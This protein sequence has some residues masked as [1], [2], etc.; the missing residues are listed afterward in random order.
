MADEQKI[1]PFTND[2]IFKVVMQDES[3]A[4]E[5]ISIILGKKVAKIKNYVPQKDKKVL[6]DAHGVRFDL[7]FEGDDA[8]YDVEMQNLSCVDIG[9][10]CRYYQSMIDVDILQTNETYFDLKDSYIIFLCTYDPFNE[11]LPIYTFESVCTSLPDETLIKDALKLNTGA[12]VVICN[13]LAYN[14]TKEELHDFLQYL[15]TQQV[16]GDNTFIEKIDEA[17]KFANGDEETRSKAMISDF[18]L[19]DARYEGKM[20]GLEAG[21]AQGTDQEQKRL[22]QILEYSQ[23]GLTEEQKQKL[24]QEFTKDREKP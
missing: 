17:V 5:I 2:E 20:E 13:A 24:I 23:V 10:R 16:A 22:I 8:V 11:G 4:K 1:Y 18:K 9:R 15:S 12:K 7:Y 19:M 6:K 14:K 21:L 3:I